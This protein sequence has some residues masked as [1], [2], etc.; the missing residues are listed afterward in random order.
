MVEGDLG[1]GRYEFDWDGK[2]ESGQL[3]SSGVYVYRLEAFGEG[4]SFVKTKKMVLL[5]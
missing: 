2:D 1:P 5:R 4:K 3:L